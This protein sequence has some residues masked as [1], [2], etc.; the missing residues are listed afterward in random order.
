[1]MSPS[2]TLIIL[3]IKAMCRADGGRL[4]NPYTTVVG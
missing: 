1:M 2:Y 4:A 3:I